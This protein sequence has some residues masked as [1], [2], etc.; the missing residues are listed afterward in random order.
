MA[1]YEPE[2]SKKCEQ[3]K[4]EADEFSSSLK[5]KLHLIKAAYGRKASSLSTIIL[6]WF[7]S[8]PRH[9]GKMAM[10]PTNPATKFGCKVGSESN[11]TSPE[12]RDGSEST[13]M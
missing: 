13:L 3:E 9:F 2:E 7:P 4:N 5:T 1:D 8:Q 12:I 10:A 11:F 6:P